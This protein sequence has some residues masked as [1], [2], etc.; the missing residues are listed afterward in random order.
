[1][2]KTKRTVRMVVTLAATMLALVALSVGTATAQEPGES[3]YGGTG[4][5]AVVCVSAGQAGASVTCT[6]TGAVPGEQL[7]V[8]A[9]A[10][11]GTVIY[12]ATLTADAAGEA[13]FGFIVPVAQRGQ[14]IT[15]KV[16]AASGEVADDSIAIAAP[17]RTGSAMPLPRTGSAQDT[18]LLA[19]AGVIMLA[20][21][22]TA[23]RRRR[24]T[25]ARDH[26]HAGR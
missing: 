1:M 16:V 10:A 21:G 24:N 25:A 22:A 3:P 20:A 12:S 15:V 13:T 17:G 23:L 19:G 7:T 2:R 11:D 4:E 8:T 14:E 26:S 5:L 9:T 6:V 18:M